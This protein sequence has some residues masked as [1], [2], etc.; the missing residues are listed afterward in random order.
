[1]A[2][3]AAFRV[4]NRSGDCQERLS[5]FRNT[6]RQEP[7]SPPIETRVFGM[8][9]RSWRDTA[10]IPYSCANTRA[11]ANSPDRR[12]AWQPTTLKRGEV[13]LVVLYTGLPRPGG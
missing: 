9:G 4:S 12:D 1:M 3:I 8:N 6:L 11:D 13:E 7:G 2:S 10:R 5:H